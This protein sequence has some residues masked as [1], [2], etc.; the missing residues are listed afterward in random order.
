MQVLI[1]AVPCYGRAVEPTDVSFLPSAFEQPRFGELMRHYRR[2]HKR[3]IKQASEE[4]GLT[5][6]TW[7]R[8]EAGTNVTIAAVAKITRWMARV[9]SPDTEAP[10][11]HPK[12][13]RRAVG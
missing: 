3:T 1:C 5:L 4:S 10:R 9:G 13:S 8:A 2:F 12:R 7:D 11:D 6:A